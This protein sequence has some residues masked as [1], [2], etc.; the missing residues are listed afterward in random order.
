[1]AEAGPTFYNVTG[2]AGIDF[3]TYTPRSNSPSGT[4]LA[5]E[6]VA[7]KSGAPVENAN[8]AQKTFRRT[9]SAQGKFAGRTV[10]DVAAD[11]K[12]GVLKPADVPVEYIVRDGNTLILNTR[13]TQAL[14]QAGIPR[15]QWNAVNKTGDALAEGRL[16]DQLRRN[17]LTSEGTPTV[18]PSGGN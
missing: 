1:V 14:E 8:F 15:S 4:P 7:P 5:P 11:L 2:D 6:A 12:S 13:S 17:K 10:G 9:F 16:T 18:R 3:S